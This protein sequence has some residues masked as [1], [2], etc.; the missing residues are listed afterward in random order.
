M[1][2][3]CG[4]LR[5]FRKVGHS[6]VNLAQQNAVFVWA[7]STVAKLSPENEISVAVNE[8]KYTH[9][10]I[11]SMVKVDETILIDVQHLKKDVI[12]IVSKSLIYEDKCHS[13]FLS[14]TSPAFPVPAELHTNW[15][16]VHTYTIQV[17]AKNRRFPF[18][19]LLTWAIFET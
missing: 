6:H 14:P 8:G 16:T 10:S 13:D 3:E 11:F 1:L 15:P 5:S 7:F 4:L 9:S 2:L 17:K 19:R 12:F 18:P